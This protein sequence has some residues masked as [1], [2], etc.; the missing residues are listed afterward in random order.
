[1]GSSPT[2]ASPRS[3]LGSLAPH[4][5]TVLGLHLVVQLVVGRGV[6][7]VDEGAYL[8]QSS[9]VVDGHWTESLPDSSF[10]GT[11]ELPVVAAPIQ[12]GTIVDETSWSAYPRHPGYPAALAGA[13]TLAGDLGP[14]LVSIVAA[15]VASV[16]VALSVRRSPIAAFW[17]ANLATPLFFHA[18]IVWAHSLGVASAAVATY[19][20]LRAK[21]TGPD[22]VGLASVVIGLAS[23]SIF[24]TESLIFAIAVVM[25]VGLDWLRN[26]RQ[27]RTLSLP[28][29]A[30]VGLVAGVA[31]DTVWRTAALHGVVTAASSTNVSAVSPTERLSALF[32]MS[33]GMGAAPGSALARLL[34][35]VALVVAVR[36]HR[37][38]DRIPRALFVIPIVLSVV[39]MHSPQQVGLLVASPL[40]LLGLLLSRRDDDTVLLGAVVGL[41]LLGV[42]G[43]MYAPDAG[44]DY[45]GRLFLAAAPAFVV[46]ATPSLVDFAKHYGRTAVGTMAAVVA[47]QLGAGWYKVYDSHQSSRAIVAELEQL[48]SSHAGALFVAP[49]IRSGRIAWELYPAGIVTVKP[50]QVGPFIAGRTMS[51]QVWIIGSGYSLE[52]VTRQI[53]AGWHAVETNSG[54]YVNAVSI[55]PIES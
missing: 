55:A 41:Y 30:V 34:L 42:V 25:V 16:F 47:L 39:A 44:L 17:L 18:Q 9:W 7:T 26:S 6:W 32:S 28:I 36:A 45:G 49:E 22:R 29:A 54:R 46:L 8:M 1:M 3:V 14:P 23:G 38:G 4:V 19:G 13:R 52:W 5:L 40:V 35:A 10:G 21:R 33:L 53:P 11:A 20:L 24:R 37:Q 2:T 51:D 43:T 15:I 48:T 27:L 12:N 50:E 31:I